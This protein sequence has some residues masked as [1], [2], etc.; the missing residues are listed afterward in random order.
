MNV[1]LTGTW[2]GTAPRWSNLTGG[3]SAVMWSK[4]S[5]SDFDLCL[6]AQVSWWSPSISGD[7]PDPKHPSFINYEQKLKWKLE[8]NCYNSPSYRQ[9]VDDIPYLSSSAK[10]NKD[11]HGFIFKKPQMLFLPARQ[12]AGIWPHKPEREQL[13]THKADILSP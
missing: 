13:L 8:V 3:R 4:H 2:P 6:H 10:K 5:T 1:M 12:Q 9:I 11:S 7:T